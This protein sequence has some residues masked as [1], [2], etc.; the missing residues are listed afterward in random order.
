MP[1]QFTGLVKTEEFRLELDQSKFPGMLRE[2]A[3]PAVVVQLKEG[4]GVQF[5]QEITYSRGAVT[6]KL[7]NR[8]DT[9]L[10]SKARNWKGVSHQSN[11]GVTGII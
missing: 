2:M 3:E 11:K 7:N 5:Q 1:V 9:R 4:G 10:K 6:F 8:I